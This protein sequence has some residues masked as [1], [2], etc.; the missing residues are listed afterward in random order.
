MTDAVPYLLQGVTP[1]VAQSSLLQSTSK[2]LNHGPL[3]DWVA[4]I[5]LRRNGADMPAP[6]ELPEM[7]QMLT[8]LRDHDRIEA[9]FTQERRINPGL[10]A[11]FVDGFLSTPSTIADYAQY[12][13]GSL[14]GEFYRRFEGQFEVEIAP[15]Q[16]APAMTQFEF[17]R[18]R[19]IQNH[20]FEHILCGGGIDALGELVPSWFRMTN[21]PRFIRDQELAGELLIIN[22]LASLRYTVRTMLHYP[23][24]WTHCADAISRGVA[25]GQ[26]SGPLFMRRI[27]PVLHLPLA[28]A[29]EVLGVRGVVDRDTQAASDFWTGESAV[30][31]APLAA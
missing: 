18:R 3:R 1:A 7:M 6:A 23:Q 28:K 2:Y 31:P 15:H 14:G 5:C 12:P 8:A 25:G 21:V 13:A 17:F 11:W 30:A 22:L 9:L 16:W 29:R 26:A 4:T 19:Q 20:D 27:E 10:D 24:V